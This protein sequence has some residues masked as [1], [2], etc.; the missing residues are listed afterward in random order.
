MAGELDE[1][2]LIQSAQRGDA[3][4]FNLLIDRYQALMYRIAL[5]MLG[6]EDDADDAA[7]TAWI[8]AF[9]KLHGFRGGQLRIW[10]ARVVVNACYDEIRRRHRRRE[11]P[12]VAANRDGDDMEAPY[13][14]QDRAPGVEEAVEGREFETILSNCLQS[15]TPVYRSML[16]LVDVE[17]MSYEDAALAAGV[18]LGTVRSRLARARMALRQRLPEAADLEA[19]SPRFSTAV[20][21]HERARCL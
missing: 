14:L 11:L 17:G 15:L 13:W 5:R 21:R 19:D 6:D 18:P 4:A 2:T 9:H 16:V 10:L 20:P 1:H 7:Q 12:L 3:Q 8:S